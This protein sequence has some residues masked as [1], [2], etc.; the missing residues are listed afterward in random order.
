MTHSFISYVR[1]DEALVNYIANILEKNAVPYWRDK[2][3]IAPGS[4]W[5][6]SIRRAIEG[7]SYYVAMFSKNWQNREVTYAN[8]ELVLAIDQLRLRP[9]NRTWFIPVKLDDCEIP[10][11][12]IGA[13]ETLRDLQIIDFAKDGWKI[14]L[15]K[16]LR[17]LGVANPLLEMGEPLGN[18]LPSNAKLGF[19]RIIVESTVPPAPMMVGLML[20]VTGGWIARTKE[21]HMLAYIKTQAPN[22]HLQQSNEKFGLDTFFAI[23]NDG[24]VSND[25]G[26]PN[27]FGFMTEHKYPANSA[28]WD[29]AT[30]KEVAIPFAITTHLEFNAFGILNKTA[31]EGTFESSTTVSTPF[32]PIQMTMAGKFDISVEPIYDPDPTI[33]VFRAPSTS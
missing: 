24:F 1:N 19:G 6:D 27:T 11:R 17:A 13:G 23:S 10:D 25:P 15:G 31:F 16:F 5:K 4:R 9:A 20:S 26:S 28:F 2:N 32:A 7:G 8:E 3:D 12:S 21:N 14:G 30:G 29:M 18:G 22:A 33:G